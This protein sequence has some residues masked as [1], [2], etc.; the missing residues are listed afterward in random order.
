MEKIKSILEMQICVIDIIVMEVAI[1][2]RINKL[3]GNLMR[4]LR[5]GREDQTCTM[6]LL[7]M[8]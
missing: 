3:G 7:K 4:C 6:Q 8:M 2:G 5:E 1:I